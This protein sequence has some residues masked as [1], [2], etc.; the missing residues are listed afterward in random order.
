MSA[1]RKPKAGK[2]KAGKKKTVER[3][4]TPRTG[5]RH[6]EVRPQPLAPER[7]RWC[8]EGVVEEAGVASTAELEVVPLHLAAVQQDANAAAV[9]CEKDGLEDLKYAIEWFV[10]LGSQ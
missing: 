9:S 8:G 5:A 3:S 1:A 4:R 6:D 10:E 7:L 2:P